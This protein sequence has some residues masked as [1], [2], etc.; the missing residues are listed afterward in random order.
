MATITN[1]AQLRQAVEQIQSLCSAIDSLRTEVFPKNPRNF[2]IMAE[3]PVDEIRKLQADID[4]YI[5]H[6]EAAG[7][8]ASD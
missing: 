4:A 8:P 5:Q 6:L 3:G 7:T 2:A 1:E